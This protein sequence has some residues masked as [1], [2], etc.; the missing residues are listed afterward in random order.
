MD[1][2][3]GQTGSSE[4]GNQIEIR[5]RRLPTPSQEEA[6]E[7]VYF[8]PFMDGLTLHRALEYIYNRLDSTVAFRPYRCGKGICMSC[9]VSVNG[10]RKQ[11]CIT[12]LK[13]GDRLL[14]EPDRARPVIRDL[15]T[16][17]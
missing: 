5:I 13:P 8:L 11:A 4:S 14:I 2:N 15:V 1:R 16:V 12:F 17:P 6:R 10:K 9:L 7:S 3:S